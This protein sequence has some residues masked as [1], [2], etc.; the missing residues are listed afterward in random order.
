ML[1]REG[2]SGGYALDIGQ[3]QAAGGQR[4]D[5][6]DVT[7]PEG[8]ACQGG[9]ARRNFSRY[10]H[11]KRRKPERGGGNDRQRDNPK[12]DRSSRQQAF[13]EYD[14]HDR[15]DPDDENEV[16][17]LTEL[18]G[19]QE[20]ALEKV[21][22]PAFHAKQARQLGHGD[23]QAG[24]GLETHKNAVADQLD[25]HAQPQQPGEQA[26]RRHREGGEAGDLGVTLRVALRHGPHC[27]GNHE[28]D[29][30]GRPDREL[31]RGSEQGIAK[32]AQQ[33]AVDAH[34][35][36]QACKAGIGKRN[37]DRVGRQGYSGDDIAHEPCSAIFSQPSGWRKP[38]KPSCHFLV[39]RRIRHGIL[40]AVN[41]FGFKY[42]PCQTGPLDSYQRI[43]AF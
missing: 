9:Q 41:W 23:R 16:L 10:R 17:H 33:V 42:R 40:Q 15:D 24:A 12:R 13:A 5:P 7:Q 35:R 18:P 2:A 43:P 26:E 28:R 34:L 38:P 8:W 21:V 27:S 29:G 25:E 22:A 20:S 1:G 36:R 19:Q 6:F 14:E 3:Q 32:T 11:P 30:G 31:T 4:N 39:F 37:R